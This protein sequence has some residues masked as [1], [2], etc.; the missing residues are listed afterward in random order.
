MIPAGFK[1]RSN[2]EM[3]YLCARN[4]NE[5]WSWMVSLERVMDF[6]YAGK[7]G[8][9]SAEFIQTKGFMGQLEFETGKYD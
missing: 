2:E 9:N 5:K 7:S 1:I 4:C 3:F 6:K 8:Y